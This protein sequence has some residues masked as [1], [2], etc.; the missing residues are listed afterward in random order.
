VDDCQNTPADFCNRLGSL[1][2]EKRS[3]VDGSLQGGATFTVGTSGGANGDG[4][5]PFAC[6]DSNNTGADDNNPVTVVDNS[7]PDANGA[8]GQFRLERVCLGTYII[9][10]TVAPAGFAIDP[11]ATRTI[12]VSAAELNPVVGAQ[13]VQN[14]CPDGGDVDTDESDFCNLVGSLFWEK[15]G[16]D[17]STPATGNELLP[18]FG[19]TVTGTGVNVVVADCTAGP[20]PAGGDQDSD[21]GQ[22]CLDQMPIGVLLTIDETTSVT[23]YVQ[24]SP[25]NNGDLTATLTQSSKCNG[26]PTDAGDFL[27]QPVSKFEIKFICVAY[28]PTNAGQCATI[29]RISCPTP[30]IVP[31]PDSR[32]PPSTTD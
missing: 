5:G 2:W 20:C 26:T 17:A 18:G 19:F 31:T 27:N 32:P 3:D 23:G 28:S 25:A 4:N 22:F 9:T 14:D 12:T 10:E 21:A 24:T 6:Q 7:A 8:D 11:D 16:K 15:R 29:A 30:A 13:G 1:Q